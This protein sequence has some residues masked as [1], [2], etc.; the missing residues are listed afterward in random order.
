MASFE[1]VAALL[2]E[3]IIEET[4]VPSSMDDF[5]GSYAYGSGSVEITRR[6]HR[7]MVQLAQQLRA[8][9]AIAESVSQRDAYDEVVTAVIDGVVAR[10]AG[11]F[12]SGR[13]AAELLDRLRAGF[14]DWT[15]LWPVSGLILPNGASLEVGGLTISMLTDAKRAAIRHDMETIGR[16][17]R[18]GPQGRPGSALPHVMETADQTLASSDYWAIGTV[19]GRRK[20][21]RWIMEER[22]TV[23]LDVLRAFALYV[24]I[25]P[26]RTLLGDSTSTAE[27]RTLFFNTARGAF[28]DV[29]L[30][31]QR[32]PFELNADDLRRLTDFSLFQRAQALSAR[33]SP[34]DLERK[35]LLGVLQFGEASRTRTAEGKLSN[36]LTAA[37]TLLARESGENDKKRWIRVARRLALYGA[38]A[39]Q[40]GVIDTLRDLYNLRRFPVHFGHRTLRGREVVT[41]TDVR[42][43][44][45]HAYLAILV[46]LEYADGRTT[47]EEL[48][49]ALDTELARRGMTPGKPV[50]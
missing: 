24:G 29:S 18:L 33:T 4:D 5:G 39:D 49:L 37:E 11:T 31:D 48:I 41:P 21:V 45:F 13:L 38:F 7:L 16:T 6:D 30:Y 12:D 42:R 50:P 19:Q 1:E 47:H 8:D 28:S 10:E 23:A 43:A 17:V 27:R 35:I 44:Q 34:T 46:S 15:V 20:S 2:N 3:I 36:Y 22:V 40:Q 26:D 25:D 32:R 14:E 9:P